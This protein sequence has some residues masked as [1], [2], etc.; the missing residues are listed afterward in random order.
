ME[1]IGNDLISFQQQQI[2]IYRAVELHD[3]SYG[4]LREFKTNGNLPQKER[5]QYIGNKIHVLSGAG[6]LYL[7]IFKLAD[8]HGH[9]D[10]DDVIWFYNVV[11]EN[12]N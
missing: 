6:L 1:I 11:K 4:L 3:I 10:I 7:L 5:L 8:I 2:S 12:K 9:A